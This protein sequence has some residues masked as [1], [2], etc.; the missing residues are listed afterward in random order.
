MLCGV[1]RIGPSFTLVAVA[2]GLLVSNGGALTVCAV[3]SVCHV[4]I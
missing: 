4:C 3:R 2:V 1:L